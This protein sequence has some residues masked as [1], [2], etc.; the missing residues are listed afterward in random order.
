MGLPHIAGSFGSPSEDHFDR[1]GAVFGEVLEAFDGLEAPPAYQGEGCIAQSSHRLWGIP[2]VGPR[3]IF[4]AGH[5]ADVMQG[6]LNAP[7]VARECE[8]AFRSSLLGGQA[9]D[10]INRLGAFLASAFA[11]NNPLAGD[12]A[13]LRQTRPKRRERLSVSSSPFFVC[14]TT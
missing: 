2:G 3:L 1:L 14:M 10:G 7:M 6:I 4:A 12:A 8:Q 11:E 5:I 9:G 13:H